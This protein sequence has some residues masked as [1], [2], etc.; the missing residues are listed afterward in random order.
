MRSMAEHESVPQQLGGSEVTHWAE[1]V[2]AV[3]A[4]ALES[5]RSALPADLP[6]V[7]EVVSQI[8]GRL[9]V[10]GVGKSG[11]I[12]RKIAATL[13]ST[14]TPAQAIHPAEA[15]H[16]D[17]GMITTQDACLAISKS[18]ETTELADV[19]AYC[20][21]FGVPL[22]AM[23]ENPKST[24]AQAA[25][26]CLTLPAVQEAC[27]IGMAPTS[28]TTVAMVMGDALAVCLMRQKGFSPD[29]FRDF[30]PGGKLG[31]QLLTVDA[32]MH[33]GDALPIVAPDT[34]MGDALVVMTGKGL[35]VAAVCD[36]TGLIGVITDGDLRRK[37]DGLLTHQAG[38]ICTRHPKTV[39]PAAL[40]SEATRIMN[41]NGITA[42]CVVNEKNQLVG[43]IHLHDCLRE[44]VV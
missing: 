15:S 43:I 28:S 32:L 44:G 1:A 4:S 8:E 34:P 5:L 3:E 22:I 19:I 41:D 27:A 31:A 16:G 13:A 39:G 42:L 29:D 24:L 17:L 12:A 14:G 2:V 25:N 21:R 38:E 30:H 33:A 36:E 40:A 18:G 23:T 6:A 9:I 10:T 7:V 26:Y 35:G 37:L 11:H 20:A